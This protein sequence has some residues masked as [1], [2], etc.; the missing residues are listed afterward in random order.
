MV[1][2]TLQIST[3][4]LISLILLYFQC[5]GVGDESHEEIMKALTELQSVSLYLSNEQVTGENNEDF[6]LLYCVMKST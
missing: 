4:S 3:Q 1:C 5:K 2:L 6:H